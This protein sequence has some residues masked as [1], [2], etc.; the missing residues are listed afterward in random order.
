M[1]ISIDPVGHISTMAC[2]K[3]VRKGI[4]YMTQRN[5]LLSQPCTQDNSKT[6]NISHG[7]TDRRTFMRL[8]K[9]IILTC[10]LGLSVTFTLTGCEAPQSS[11]MAQAPP[12]LPTQPP[13]RLDALPDDVTKMAP[14]TDHHPPIMHSNEWLSLIHISEPTRPY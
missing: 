7:F 2:N 10:L 4:Y 1:V 8:L 14:S 11:E 9:T 6:S 3:T 5:S 12:L 13:T